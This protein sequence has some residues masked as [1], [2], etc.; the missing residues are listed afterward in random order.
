M[1]A[2]LGAQHLA[3]ARPITVARPLVELAPTVTGTIRLVADYAPMQERTPRDGRAQFVTRLY[4]TG[5]T[6]PGRPE[7]EISV[8]PVT[9]P[10][11]PPRYRF[12][13]VLRRE[14][15]KTVKL[16]RAYDE[17]PRTQ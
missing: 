14:Q 15:R 2:C 7:T 12:G 3:I 8:H 1:K 11:R 4:R 6:V 16:R 5:S 9:R 17:R 10:P 13:H